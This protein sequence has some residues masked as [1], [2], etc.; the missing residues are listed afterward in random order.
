MTTL[1]IILPD[2]LAPDATA[3]GLLT[4][5]RLEATLNEQLREAA[6]AKLDALLL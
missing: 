6:Q 1:E 2:D 5:E 4:R 3:A